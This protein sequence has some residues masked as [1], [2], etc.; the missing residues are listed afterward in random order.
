MLVL[1][2]DN[3]MTQSSRLNTYWVTC[4]DGLE[5][6]LVEELQE[7][8]QNQSASITEKKAGR[9][10]I[11]GTLETAY[12]ICLWSR[13][14]SRVLLP[15]HEEQKDVRRISMTIARA[16]HSMITGMYDILNLIRDELE[17]MQRTCDG[18]LKRLLGALIFC[19]QY[20]RT[21]STSLKN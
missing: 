5:N 14:A 4:A 12:R 3:F 11:Q 20:T 13:L 16:F 8:I 21:W 18:R 15:I 6:L 1:F 10:I 7:L 9:I 17:Q 19:L 2:S